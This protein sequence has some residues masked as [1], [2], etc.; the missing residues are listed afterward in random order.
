MKSAN[1]RT[2]DHR[3]RR[4]PGLSSPALVLAAIALLVA[5]GG[6]AYAAVSLPK[7]SVGSAQLRPGA[8]DSAKVRNGSLRVLDF[9]AATR[10][11]LTGSPGPRGPAGLSGVET[12]QASSDFAST[13]ERTVILDCPPGKRLIGGGAGAWGRAMIWIPRGVALAVSQPVDED[14]WV[15][16][17]Q[18]I[19]ET[20]ESWFLQAR[21]VCAAAS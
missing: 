14:T 11:A 6:T 10:A 8:V 20:D 1:P 7:N 15:A 16:K 2:T 21:I 18:E 13:P 19:V 4:R 5:L 3:L 12:V 17:A 9:A